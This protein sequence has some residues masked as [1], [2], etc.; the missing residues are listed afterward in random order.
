MKYAE[1]KK[2]NRQAL[3]EILVAQSRRIDE[4]EEQLA[5]AKAA[6]QERSIMMDDAGSIAEA[7]LKIN[8]VFEAAQAAADQYLKGVRESGSSLVHDGVLAGETAGEVSP[9]AV[10]AESQSLPAD[11]VSDGTEPQ[12]AD[13]APSGVE[14]Q[15]S[16]DM[17][18]KAEPQEVNGAS[19]NIEPGECV[20]AEPDSSAAEQ[21]Q[22]PFEPS[23]QAAEPAQLAQEP[24]QQPDGAA[25]DMPTQQLGESAPVASSEQAPEMQA[26]PMQDR[27]RMLVPDPRPDASEGATLEAHAP[28]GKTVFQRAKEAIEA[29]LA[30]PDD[31][32]PTL[33]YGPSMPIPSEDG[34]TLDGFATTAREEEPATCAPYGA[35]YAIS[36]EA[37]VPAQGTTSPAQGAASPV[38]PSSGDVPVPEHG[39]PVPDPA[40]VPIQT[41]AAEQE[42]QAAFPHSGLAQAGTA[43]AP[44]AS[45]PMP[46]YAYPYP[47]AGPASQPVPVEQSATGQ[48]YMMPV[49]PTAYGAQGASPAYMMPMP[50]YPGYAYAPTPMVQQAAQQQAAGRREPAE[51]GDAHEA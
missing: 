11:G 6:L 47:Y 50:W 9:C 44:S 1:L 28:H 32:V 34:F 10:S 18:A 46:M 29:G 19:A 51:R 40:P 3:L 49:Y 48:S 41:M 8:E 39:S 20:P 4:L 30:E 17:S 22:Q 31:D 33:P 7:A 14:P 13:G 38:S 37:A 26:V 5:E 35:H 12:V 16:D 27:F 45:Q 36:S 23:Q 24:G 15:V 2:L 42:G 43:S 25:A 21:G